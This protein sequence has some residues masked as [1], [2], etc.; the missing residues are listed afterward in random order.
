MYSTSDFALAMK[1]KMNLGFQH[2]AD[3]RAPYVQALG[4]MPQ[5]SFIFSYPS[6]PNIVNVFP[7]PVCPGANERATAQITAPYAKIVAEEIR[8][9]LGAAMYHC[10]RRRRL[11]VDRRREGKSVGFPPKAS[12]VPLCTYVSDP[13]TPLV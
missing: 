7:A 6:G 11:C 5:C 13:E 12:G 10:I 2:C 1:S 9:T 8:H 4:T 3:N